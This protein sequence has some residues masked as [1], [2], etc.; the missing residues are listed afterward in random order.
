MRAHTDEQC[1][2]ASEPDAKHARRR[3]VGNNKH[4]QHS[5]AHKPPPAQP[6]NT[7]R[8]RHTP[9]SNRWMI[10][11]SATRTGG[12]CFSM[13]FST[14]TS[15]S[16]CMRTSGGLLMTAKCGDR[17]STSRS[18]ASRDGGLERRSI[19]S[20][21]SCS[22]LRGSILACQLQSLHAYREENNKI[23]GPTNETMHGY[24]DFGIG[25]LG[26]ALTCE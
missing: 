11:R 8:N 23:R 26:Y 13:S 22:F 15:N 7:K 25:W 10:L 16:P 20:S 3:C 9:K 17:K 24:S 21:T 18:T 4:S 12:K 2:L 5:S 19:S 6:H 14:V 1:L